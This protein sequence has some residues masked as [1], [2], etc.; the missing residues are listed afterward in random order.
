[1]TGLKVGQW[2]TLSHPHPCIKIRK[3]LDILAIIKV[4]PF[5]MHNHES[6]QRR[7]VLCVH[8]R[9]RLRLHLRHFIVHRTDTSALPLL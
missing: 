6:E 9:L 3:L 1:M 5:V 2:K 4:K 8:L 7:P